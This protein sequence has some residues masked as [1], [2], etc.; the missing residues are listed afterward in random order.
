MTGTWV[1]ISSLSHRGYKLWTVTARQQHGM[2]VIRYLLDKYVPGC[3]NG[4]H[5]VW[6]RSEEGSFE[7]I[8]KKK[9]M[10]SIPGEKI[11]FF[12]DSP[13]EIKDTKDFISSFLFDPA[14]IHKPIEGAGLVKSWYE[15][16]N[17]LL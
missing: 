9:F 15:I 7:G 1:F 2:K 12:D 6:G 4:I 17:M 10:E 3:I 5:C 13:D 14:G 8:S 11:A 16:G